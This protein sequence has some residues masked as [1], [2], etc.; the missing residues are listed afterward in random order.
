MLSGTLRKLLW[1]NCVY[2][3]RCGVLLYIYIYITLIIMASVKSFFN[4]VILFYDCEHVPV[5]R[6]NILSCLNMLSISFYS[7]T[8]YI[9][10]LK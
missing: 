7:V 4:S 10:I 3:F 5:L 9:S 2:F 6:V 8:L 1:C